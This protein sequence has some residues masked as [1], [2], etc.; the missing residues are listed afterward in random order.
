MVEVKDQLERQAVGSRQWV[1]K[2][3]PL[4][5]VF[6]RRASRIADAVILDPEPSSSLSIEQVSNHRPASCVHVFALG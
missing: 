4:Q 3:W 6:S 5:L 2:L 1:A